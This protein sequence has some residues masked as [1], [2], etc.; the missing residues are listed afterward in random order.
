MLIEFIT[1]D[2][3]ISI[4]KF[5]WHIIVYFLIFLMLWRKTILLFVD[6]I[7]RIIRKWIIHLDDDSI[8]AR[9]NNRAGFE[10][11]NLSSFDNGN[12]LIVAILWLE[13]LLRAGF[14]IYIFTNS[15]FL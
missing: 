2:N 1:F 12:Q 10:V 14:V 7:Y 13:L 8:V 6:N 11:I 9:I 15:S 5:V 3:I 4:L